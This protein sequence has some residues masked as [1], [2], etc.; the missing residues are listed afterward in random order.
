LEDLPLVKR[1]RVLIADNDASTRVL[2]SSL[3]R[4]SAP[5]IEIMGEAPDGRSALNLTRDLLPD[6][7]IMDV[8]MP[9][10]SGV[11]A[12][13]AILS[14][15]PDVQVIELSIFDEAE[16]GKEMIE[17]GAPGYFC[18]SQPWDKTVSTIHG[19]LSSKEQKNVGTASM[20]ERVFFPAGT[21]TRSLTLTVAALYG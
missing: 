5:D 8:R 9:L 17:A 15:F 13:R 20:S 18:K 4:E 1:I 11:E 12:G 19:F 3:F 2:L 6:A 7:V 10:M 14:E 16:A 21:S